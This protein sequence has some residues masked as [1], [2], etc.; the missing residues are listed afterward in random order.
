VVLSTSAPAEIEL[1]TANATLL[2]GVSLVAA[3]DE[4]GQD[5]L[6]MLSESLSASQA[7]SPLADWLEPVVQQSWIRGYGLDYHEA[8]GVYTRTDGYAMPAGHVTQTTIPGGGTATPIVAFAEYGGDLWAAEEGSGATGGRVLR[9]AGGSGTA[10]ANSTLALGPGEILRDLLVAGDGAGNPMLWAS[11]TNTSGNDGRLHRWDGAVWTSSAVGA[12]GTNGRNRMK[13]VFW[14]TQDGNGAWRIVSISGRATLAYTLPNSDPLLGASWVEDVIVATDS[15]LDSLA[16]ARQHVWVGSKTNVYDLTA[17]GDSP[18]LLGYDDTTPS[19]IPFPVQ[20]HDGYLY[21]AGA[22]SL[23]RTQVDATATVQEDPGQCAPGWGTRTES[24]WRGY[25]TALTVDQGYLVAAVWNPTTEKTGL[26]WGK[27]RSSFDQP[28]QAESPNP[29]IWYGPEVYTHQHR[30]VTALAPSMLASG[31]R[32]LW[33]GSL[34]LPS[35]TP[36]IVYASLPVSGAPIAD[37][38]SGGTHRYATGLGSAVWNP[39]CTLRS[40]PEVW[41]DQNSVKFIYQVSVAARGLNPSTGTA[42]RSWLRADPPLG[43]VSYSGP[44]DTTQNGSQSYTPALT[45]VGYKLDLR[46]DFFSPSGGATPPEAAVLDAYRMTA[47]R[48]APSL[49]VLT[50]DVEYGDAVANLYGARDSAHHPDAV[51]EYL[52]TLASF[53]PTIMR[54]P[55]GRRWHVKLRQVLDSQETYGTGGP[56]GKR[57][58][59]RIQVGI[60]GPA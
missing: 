48:V 58:R 5:T 8:A 10:W 44:N 25:V 30:R 45:T 26:F 35:N 21:R 32:R 54:D 13:R 28:M 23:T 31:E 53:G 42:I 52:E 46:L 34:N 15:T 51:K 55:G 19:G 56:W 7:D 41:N 43:S 20:Y 16:A 24:E 22:G 3:T 14:R 12:Y 29:L 9:L 18:A 2:F 17:E 11:S 40:M 4:R 6:R 1:L 60:L 49:R 47:W 50:L 59:S 57:V 38:I 33:I 39:S 36:E 27:P 37:L